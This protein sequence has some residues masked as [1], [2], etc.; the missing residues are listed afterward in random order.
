M[1]YKLVRTE[2]ARSDETILEADDI[3]EMARLI[4]EKTGRG[5]VGLGS[6]GGVNLGF[7]DSDDGGLL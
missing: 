5:G 2:H 4:Q 3:D 6:E 1:K 7:G